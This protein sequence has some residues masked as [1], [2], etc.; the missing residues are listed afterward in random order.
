MNLEFKMYDKHSSKDGRDKGEM[1]CC[2]V[3]TLYLKWPD[4]VERRFWQ[5]NEYMGI[6]R[7]RMK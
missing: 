6:Y 5:V 1:Q 2:K 3:I 4:S 7:L